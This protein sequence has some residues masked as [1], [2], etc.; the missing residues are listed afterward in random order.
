[1]GRK[2]GLIEHILG[3]GRLF[4]GIGISGFGCRA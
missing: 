2:F 4:E 3:L 1:M